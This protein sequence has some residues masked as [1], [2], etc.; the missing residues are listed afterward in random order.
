MK[1]AV[2]D[3]F[4][5]ISRVRLPDNRHLAYRELGNPSGI[6]ILFFHG[7]PGSSVQAAVVPVRSAYDDFRVIAVD[8]P[9]FGYSSH[10]PARTH[11]SFARDLKSLV[12][13][14]QLPP[15]HLLSVSGGTPYAFAAASVLG[16][17]ALSLNSVGGLGPLSEASFMSEMKAFSQWALKTSGRFAGAANFSMTLLEMLITREPKEAA[18]PKIL[19]LLLKNLPASDQALIG[20][21]EL[22]RKFRLSMRNS[23]RNGPHG[24]S[25]DL[26]LMTQAWGVD[27]SELKLPVR[28]WHG[29]VDSIV[30]VNHS[31]YL[32]KKIPHSELSIL[33]GEGHYSVPLRRLMNVLDR[34]R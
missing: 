21:E 18:S 32:A 9:G 27:F 3:E 25:R 29:D 28:L 2:S 11:L 19:K 30:P 7:F 26:H 10:D 23:F 31:V 24:A 16:A 33:K 15:L 34:M 12:E 20:N 5:S 1:D 17:H 22:R 14:L 4:G 8:R 6:P 13:Q